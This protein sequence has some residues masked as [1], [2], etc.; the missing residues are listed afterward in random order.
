MTFQVKAV[1]VSAEKGE[2]K[3]PVDEV[4]C[5]AHHG[6]KGDA[7]AGNWHRQVSFL[8]Q[9]AVELMAEKIIKQGKKIPLTP[10]I[11]AENILTRG[12]D[13]A[14]VKVGARIT[15]NEVELEV[16]QIGKTCHSG[17][18]IFKIVGDCIM[19]R[20]GI[21]TKVLKGGVIRAGD[22]GHYHL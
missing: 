7:H 6:I 22:R 8:S 12:I 18:A 5:V 19:P 3:K 10:G 14:S 9:E 1:N 16:T 20:Q 21:F 17:C 2:V 15:I 11:F 13:W 4:H